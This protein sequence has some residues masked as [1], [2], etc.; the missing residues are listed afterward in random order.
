MSGAISLQDI[1]VTYGDV[2]AVDHVS[3]DIQPGEFVSLLGPSGSGKTTILRALA[4]FNSPK[5]GR[6][7]D[8]DE[9]I[10]DLPPR[11]RDFG[12]VFQS[13]ALFPHMSVERNVEFGLRAQK[14]RRTSSDGMSVAEILELVGLSDFSDRYPG[15]LSGGQQQRVALARA[16]VI[17]PRLLLMDEPL[18][19]LDLNLRQ[20]LQLE[21]RRIQQ[22]LGISTLYVT[23]DQEEALSLSDRVVV[24]QAGKISSQGSPLDVYRRPSTR[25]TASFIG[26]RTILDVPQGLIDEAGVIRDLPGQQG[27]ITRDRTGSVGDEV[28]SVLLQPEDVELH[29]TA[30]PDSIEGRVLGRRFLGRV[31]L[32]TVKAGD[33]TFY[34]TDETVGGGEY[35]TGDSVHVR[36]SSEDALLIKES[37][38]QEGASDNAIH[39]DAS[40]VGIPPTDA[41]AVQ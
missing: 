35:D 26:N 9:D 2:T 40:P 33:V 18:A 6:I 39:S 28:L 14:E 41:K 19:A 1:H 17:H 22:T 38:A 34:A 21:I 10:T 15:Q 3:L 27:D 32:V 11:F 36:W 5:S 4:G 24:M 25:F 31:G 7:L 23:H 20:Q 37:R 12:M 13:Y 8:G 16:I 29:R 30:V